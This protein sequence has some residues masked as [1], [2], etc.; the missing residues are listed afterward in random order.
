[1]ARPHRTCVPT[2]YIEKEL[3]E[4]VGKY[5]LS[6][7][8]TLTAY[9]WA[10]ARGQPCATNSSRHYQIACLCIAVWATTYYDRASVSG[11]RE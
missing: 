1:M 9:V 4:Y 3:R 2:L 5:F 10:L 8:M 11:E 6:N 7:A